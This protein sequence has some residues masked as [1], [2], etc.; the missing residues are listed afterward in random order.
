MKCSTLAPDSSGSVYRKTEHNYYAEKNVTI[1]LP[2]FFLYL[3][4]KKEMKFIET[5]NEILYYERIHLNPSTD[6]GQT[7]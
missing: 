7:L 5:A 3:E 4:H 6:K 1:R 2:C